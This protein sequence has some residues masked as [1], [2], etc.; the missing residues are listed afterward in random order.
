MNVVL[1][2]RYSS[3]NQ[4]EQSIE[5]QERVCTE[6]CQRNGYTIVNK[7]ID[8]AQSAFKDTDKRAEFQRMIKDSDKHLWEAVV[9]YKLDR[10]ARNR[11][12]SATYKAKLKRNGVRLISATENITDN[13][14][15]IILESVLEG[16]AEFYSKEL[17]QKIRR[18]IR[19]SAYKGN[20][21]GG[22]VPLGYKIENHKLVEDPATSH[23]VREAFDLYVSGHQIGEICELFNQKGY[24]TTKGAK[25]NKC[26]FSSIFKNE[27]YIGVYRFKDIVVEDAIPPLIDRDTFDK[28][29]I[30]RQKNAHAPASSKANVRYLLTGKLFCGHCGS[31]MVGESGK[32][33]TGRM[34]SYYTCKNRKRAHICKKKP[35]QKDFIENYVAEYSLK[36]LTDETIDTIADIAIKQNQEDINNDQLIISLTQ[37]IKDINNSINNLLKLVEKGIESESVSA[38]LIELEQQKRALNAQLVDAQSDYI[39]LEKEHII[40][41]L[42][43]FACGDI[44]N[45]DFRRQI[46]DLLVN[47]V[48]VWDTPEGYKITIT[49]NL[50]QGNNQTVCVR[51]DI[52]CQTPPQQN[53]PNFFVNRKVFGVTLLYQQ[54]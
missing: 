3:N 36:L 12:D 44:Q 31:S 4:S 41:W 40:W 39:Y 21:I 2:M 33:E 42:S 6:F 47:S 48:T 28:A 24:R 16:M 8:R 52:E 22:S 17:S 54:T 18:G 15:G 1:Y 30:R 46:I 32:S 9:V 5:G 10:F 7:Y 27:K 14:E 38:R 45:E 20:N 13:P 29:Q 34:Y 37:S 50:I 49:F 26:S 25:F 19:E 51:S 43:Q 11:Y 35:I 23:I 53:N